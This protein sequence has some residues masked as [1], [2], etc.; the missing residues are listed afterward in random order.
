MSSQHQPIP[1]RIMQMGP[2]SRAAWAAKYNSSYGSWQRYHPGWRHDLLAAGLGDNPSLQRLVSRT[3]PQF[4]PTWRKL[5]YGIMQ[6]DIARVVWLLAHGGIYADLDTEALRHAA[7]FL[8]NASIVLVANHTQHARETGCMLR[9]PL[10]GTHMSNAFMAGVAGHPFWWELLSYTTRHVD[11][12]CAKKENLVHRVPELT[13]PFAVG[14]TYERFV[15]AHPRLARGIRVLP[16]QP[17][18]FLGKSEASWLKKQPV[19][20]N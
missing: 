4:L 2:P 18:L 16:R 7:P 1:R 13:G 9:K 8:E 10:C 6:I 17:P 14:R 11:E 12:V 5:C 19:K 15:K 20:L 3:V